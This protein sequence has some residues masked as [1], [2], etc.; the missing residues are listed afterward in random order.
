MFVSAF[1]WKGWG[2]EEVGVEE[3]EG[4]GPGEGEGEGGVQVEKER[5]EEEEGEELVCL[6]QQEEGEEQLVGFSQAVEGGPA[7]TQELGHLKEQYLHLHA[8]H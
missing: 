8:F 4:V 5:L 6:K 3:G 7:K 1:L 2:W